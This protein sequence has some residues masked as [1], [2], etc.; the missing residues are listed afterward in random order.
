MSQAPLPP[1][2]V[3]SSSASPVAPV[4]TLAISCQQAVRNAHAFLRPRSRRYSYDDQQLAQGREKTLAMLIADPELLGS[5]LPPAAPDTK[6][7]CSVLMHE[8]LKCV[9][10]NYAHTLPNCGC[11]HLT[12]AKGLCEPGRKIDE[13]TRQALSKVP[14][15]PFT[16]CRQSTEWALLL[17]PVHG[18]GWHVDQSHATRGCGV[19]HTIKHFNG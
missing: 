6:F 5:P 13:K 16:N 10:I 12:K 19:A 2:V 3:S 9:V 11:W 7:D 1:V 17:T 14:K 18:H 8:T 4:M 15:P